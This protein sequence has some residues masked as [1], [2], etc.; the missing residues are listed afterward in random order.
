MSRLKLTMLSVVLFVAASVPASAQRSILPQN[1]ELS[2]VGLERAW[3]AQANMDISRD[4]LRSVVAD[5]SIVV[6]QATSGVVTAFDAENGRQLWTTQLGRKDSYSYPAATNEE[7]VVIVGGTRMYGLNKLRGNIEWEMQIQFQPS[8]SPML[9]DNNLYVGTLTGR[10]LAYDIK[11][12]AELFRENKVEGFKHQTLR[13]SYNTAHKITSPPVT[14]GR[15]LLFSSRDN[16]LYSLLSESGAFEFQFETDSSVSAPMAQFE[17][18][19]LMA[20]HDF[21]LYCVDSS[22]GQLKW[23]YPAGRPILKAPVVIGKQVFLSPEPNGIFS[24]DY[25]TGNRQWFRQRLTQFISA[26]PE[27][28][29]ASDPAKNIVAVNR[30]NGAVIG[31]MPGDRFPMR[32]HNDRTDRLYLASTSGRIVCLRQKGMKFPIYHKFPERRPIIPELY[33][34]PA[35]RP[36]APNAADEPVPGGD[37]NLPAGAGAAPDGNDA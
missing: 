26:T 35:A 37:Q 11:K 24:I 7:L 16:S 13:W 30:K 15:N 3:W 28:L 33:E 27:I 36:E 5:E 29:Y 17:N 23:F 14:T 9:D 31:F 10:I 25:D 2:R 8:T 32:V 34:E 12:I 21:R 1:D 4:H 22:T 6:M 19:V 20:A 18:T